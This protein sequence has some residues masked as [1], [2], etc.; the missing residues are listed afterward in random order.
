MANARKRPHIPTTHANEAEHRRQIATRVNEAMTRDGTVAMKEPL[1]L[2]QR[3]VADLPDASLW[4]G[5]V[6]YVIDETGGAVLAFSDGSDWRRTT[7]R[8]VVA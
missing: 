3:A 8:A 7:D 2:D 6:L 5:S 4:E 1:L